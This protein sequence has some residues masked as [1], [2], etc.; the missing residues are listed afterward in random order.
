MKIKFALPSPVVNTIP[1]NNSIDNGSGGQGGNGRITFVNP[2]NTATK[3]IQLHWN[4]AQSTALPNETVT[5]DKSTPVT[6]V[7]S[8]GFLKPPVR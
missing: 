6:H 7:S 4:T 3:N 1:G 8:R 2:G 5:V